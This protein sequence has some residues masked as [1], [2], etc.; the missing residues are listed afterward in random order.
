MKSASGFGRVIHR[1]LSLHL[2]ETHIRRAHHFRKGSKNE[3]PEPKPEMMVKAWGILFA[4]K[5]F[6]VLIALFMVLSA[7]V[8]IRLFGH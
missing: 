4:G 5:P 1:V 3:L 2:A 7:V 8:V 6:A